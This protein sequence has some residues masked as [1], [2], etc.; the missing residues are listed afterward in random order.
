MAQRARQTY[1]SAL[2]LLDEG[3]VDRAIVELRNTSSPPDHPGK[4]ARHWP[5]PV[6]GKGQ[7]QATSANTCVSSNNPDDADARISCPKSRSLLEVGLERHGSYA[8][9]IDPEQ[10]ASPWRWIMGIETATSPAPVD[11]QSG[12]RRLDRR[13]HGFFARTC[14]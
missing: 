8:R 3:D 11:L 10:R 9:D 13:T 2:T 5:C 4:P 7:R 6:G 14:S 1:Q 12:R